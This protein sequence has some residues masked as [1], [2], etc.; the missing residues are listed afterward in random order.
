MY[1]YVSGRLVL[2]RGSNVVIDV[3]GIGYLI[4]VPQSTLRSLPDVGSNVRVL[5][6]FHVTDSGQQLFGFLT[7][8]ERD[9]FKNLISISGIGP[10][11]A[12]TV[13]SG[14][15]TGQFAELLAADDV[16]HLTAIPGIGKKTA[17]RII[18]ELKSKL[19]QLT[20]TSE[21][22]VVPEEAI[23]ALQSL[24]YSQYEVKKVIEKL[25]SQIGRDKLAQLSTEDFL[26]AALSA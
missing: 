3:G 19:P 7:E 14:V 23:L 20:A 13:L 17:A 6:H 12:L 18:V 11:L 10:K 15:S 25:S 4:A 2:K 9:I 8:A 26:K 5:T 24:G 16:A 1:E 21:Q 22:A